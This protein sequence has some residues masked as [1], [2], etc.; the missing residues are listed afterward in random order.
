MNSIGKCI[1]IASPLP[2]RRAPTGRSSAR[3]HTVDVLDPTSQDL[4]T[5]R[6]HELKMQPRRSRAQRGR[7]V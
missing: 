2:Y 1:G 6:I 5:K 3:L 4:L 7:C